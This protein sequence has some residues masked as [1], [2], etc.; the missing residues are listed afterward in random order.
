M[1]AWKRAKVLEGLTVFRRFVQNRSVEDLKPITVKMQEIILIE[2]TRDLGQQAVIKLPRHERLTVKA[3]DGG[4]ALAEEDVVGCH[5]L[6]PIASG[7][8]LT[9][10]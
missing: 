10:S 4:V 8:K 1:P 9:C 6:G 7:K 2:R 3:S 5:W